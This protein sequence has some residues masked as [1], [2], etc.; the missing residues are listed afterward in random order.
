MIALTDRRLQTDEPISIGYTRLSH[1]RNRLSHRSGHFHWRTKHLRSHRLP[2]CCLCVDGIRLFVQTQA[3]ALT[4]FCVNGVQEG[5]S[6]KKGRQAVPLPASAIFWR[7]NNCAAV[8]DL[9]C[10]PRD[11]RPQARPQSYG[12]TQDLASV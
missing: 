5:C 4:P 8:F 9:L 12:E 2:C 6:R 11:K 3:F 10:D 1:L 7:S